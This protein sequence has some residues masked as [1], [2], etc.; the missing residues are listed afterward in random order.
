MMRVD[1]HH[2]F[3]AYS[4]EEYGWIQENMGVLRKDFLP[5]ELLKETQ[6][7]HVDYVVSVQARQD[8]RETKFLL[9]QSVGH[10]WIRGV[11]GW[12]PLADPNVGKT[13]EALQAQKLLKGVRHVVQDEPDEHFLD[14]EDFNA[15]IRLLKGVDWV[16]DLLVFGKQ[17]P[18]T[19]R[20]VDRHPDQRFVLD[21]IAKPV[22]QSS[23]IDQQWERD[24]REL[25]KRPNV[26][27][28]FS[29]LVTEVRDP[30]WTVES[31]RPY[32]NVAIHAFGP[33]RLMFGS[34]WPVCL[35][36]ATYADWV[37]TVSLFASELSSQE[38][39]NFWGRNAN[40]A[41]KLGIE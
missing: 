14:R 39:A 34:D 37:A 33:D 36:R 6:A 29:A 4:K 40:R 10:P 28:K 13:I 15:G 1:S 41:Y 27:C 3:W 5:Q 21:H 9:D 8:L 24:F 23:G 32:W 31:L 7:T 38:Q 19:I 30:T 2:H 26:M 16:Y 18:M 20:F 12:I 22:I 35:L 25:A 11:V 17:L